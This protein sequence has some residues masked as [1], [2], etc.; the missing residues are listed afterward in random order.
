MSAL[1]L[2]PAKPLARAKARLGEVFSTE[3]RRTLALA[4]LRDVIAA[5]R[6]CGDVWVVCS[7]AEVEEVARGGGAVALPDATPDAG[8]N[9]SLAAATHAIERAG[10]DGV[11][12]LSS[13]LPCVTPDDIVAMLAPPGVAIA[14]SRDGGTN[15]LW[16]TPPGVIETAFGPGSRTAHER[17]AREAGV[18]SAI[19]ERAGLALDV[20]DP[21]DLVAA[22]AAGAGP[23]TTAAV[24]PAF[25]SRIGERYRSPRR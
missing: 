23:A 20:D 9:P 5:A 2:V 6:A 24:D 7:D 22:L 21:S 10:Y 17:L 16:R 15:A 14:P 8:L 1:C 11:L 12:V 4:M 3:E 13:D 18:A 19:V 25:A